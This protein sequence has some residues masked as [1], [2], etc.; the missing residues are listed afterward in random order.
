MGVLYRFTCNSP[1]G[2]LPEEI[3]LNQ[4]ATGANCQ[5][6]LSLPGKVPLTCQLRIESKSRP[7]RQPRERALYQISGSSSGPNTI[8]ATYPE[9]TSE[10][11]H[12]CLAD[13]D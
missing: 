13:K 8:G 5:P 4:G 2:Y 9:S 12:N 10:N 3:S 6:I 11:A 7:Y 1:P